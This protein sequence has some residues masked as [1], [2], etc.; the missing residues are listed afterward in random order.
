MT[1]Q[2]ATDTLA[3]LKATKGLVSDACA[4]LEKVRESEFLAQTQC[5]KAR[6]ELES[7]LLN[8]T[9]PFALFF[10]LNN[11]GSLCRTQKGEP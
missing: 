5:E 9:H 11:L 2:S 10:S 4:E 8:P 6:I 3:E 7:I 1:K